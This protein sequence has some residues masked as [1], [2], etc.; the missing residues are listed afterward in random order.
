MYFSEAQQPLL[1][2]TEGSHNRLCTCELTLATEGSAGGEGASFG[3]TE[4]AP[5]QACG[6]EAIINPS[7]VPPATLFS[8]R[9][10]EGDPQPEMENYQDAFGVYHSTKRPREE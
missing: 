4:S 1:L 9:E 10:A 3:G 2:S 5:S 6:G 8:T 7:A